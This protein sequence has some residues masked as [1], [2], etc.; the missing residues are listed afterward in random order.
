MSA[1]LETGTMTGLLDI[2]QR[3]STVLTKFLRNDLKSRPYWLRGGI[4]EGPAPGRGQGHRPGP[5]GGCRS[6]PA[7]V[8]RVPYIA[9]SPRAPGPQPTHSSHIVAS[10]ARF[11]GWGTS[12]SSGAGLPVYPPSTHPVPIPT[13]P[14]TKLT[15]QYTVPYTRF[16]DPEGE[17]RGI[18]TQPVLRV[19]DWLYTVIC[20]Y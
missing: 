3:H 2:F 16:W 9:F 17:P 8:P 15:V 6:R 19:P 18:R 10:G 1:F 13:L 4:R 12:S 14:C 20:Q 11:A 7:A 5:Q